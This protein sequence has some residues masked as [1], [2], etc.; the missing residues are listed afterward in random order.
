MIQRFFVVL[1]REDAL[2]WDIH[3]LEEWSEIWLLRFNTGKCHVLKLGKTED[4]MY[5]H[6]YKLYGSN[7]K[8]VFEKK[9]LGVT[10]DSELKFEEHISN[11]VNKANSIAGLIRRSFAHLDGPLLKRLYTTFVSAQATWSLSSQ[12]F[13]DMLENVQKRA[14]KMV[15]GI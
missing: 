13:I 9:D 6:N 7:L 5:T 1:S 11:K 2:Q 4:I 8:H 14:T 15:D 3:K 12:K 10:I